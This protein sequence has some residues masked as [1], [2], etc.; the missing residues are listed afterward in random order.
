MRYL[1]TAAVIAVALAAAAAPAS[2]GTVCVDLGTAIFVEGNSGDCASSAPAEDNDLTV[3]VDPSG[4]IVFTDSNPIVDDGSGCVPAGNTATCPASSFR[5]ALGSLND[6]ATIAAAV[7]GNP[8]GLP[9]DLGAGADKL[10]GGPA[11]DTVTGGAGGDEMNGGGGDDALSGGDGG[12]VIRGGDGNDALSGDADNDTIEGGAGADALDGGGHS[13]TVDGGDDSD[14][15]DGGTGNDAVKGGNGEDFLESSRFGCTSGV[16]ADA[17][18]GGPGGDVLCGGADGD[19]INGGSGVDWA[20]YRGRPGAVT[21]SLDGAANDGAPGEGDLIANDVEG[22]LGGSGGDTLE[23]A[24]G[25]QLLDGGPGP[26]IVRGH[27]GDDVL[28]DT[29]ADG[30][31]DALEGGDGDDVLSGGDGPDIYAGGN[32][33]DTVTDYAARVGDVTATIDDVANDGEAGEGDDVRTDVEDLHGGSGNDTLTGSGGDN[34][35]TGGSGSDTIDGGGGNDGIHGGA[36]ADTLTGGGGSDLAEGDGGNDTIRVRDGLP[37]RPSCG[38]GTDRAEVDTRDDAFAD[39]E[40]LDVSRPAPAV[41]RSTVVSRAGFVITAVACPSTERACA[42]GVTVKSVRRIA[43]R[44]RTLGIKSYR[45]LGGREAIVR[46]TIPKSERRVLKRARRVKVRTIVT[47]YNSAT[48]E[49]STA[50]RTFT[51]RTSGLRA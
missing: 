43:G 5:F 50:A 12:D 10:N 1:L 23:G 35:L 34:E 19:S 30:G 40:T 42:G 8:F 32:G 41:I 33:V 36:G 14:T 28:G 46:A 26:D 47:N 20:S 39:C 27:G 2:A 17:L 49:R 37:D 15:L 9:S 4:A 48:G 29:G 25:T 7:P 13:D 38:G 18:D 51:V 31:G 22:L 6:T 16:G 45:V 24:E 21:M 44:V 11:A 3:S